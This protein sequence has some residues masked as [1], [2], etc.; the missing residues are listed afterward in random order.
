MNRERV[1]RATVTLTKKGGRGVLTTDNLILTAAHCID[2]KTTGEMTLG[3]HFIETIRTASGE[4]CA[5]RPL[6]VEPLAD[7]AV[8]GAL[9]EQEFP[10]HIVESFETFCDATEPVPVCANVPALFKP[11]SVC[12]FTHKRTWIEG[13]AK[14]M[15]RYASKFFVRVNEPI[16]GGTSGSPIVNKRGELVGIVCD[17]GTTEELASHGYVS[18]GASPLPGALPLWMWWKNS[19]KF[20]ARDRRKIKQFM[21]QA[22]TR[23]QHPEK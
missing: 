16:E 8:L 11:F 21:A 4:E 2:F 20:E 5:V 14:L 1:E 18:V 17:S 10:P 12:I 23:F 19:H 6:A 13:T 7:I 9:D 3:E 15:D 22:R